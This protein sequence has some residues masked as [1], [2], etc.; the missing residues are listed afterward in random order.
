MNPP[1][2]RVSSKA[3]KI[4]SIGVRCLG[5]RMKGRSEVTG[6][7]RI[8]C[9][10]RANRTQTAVELQ[11]IVDHAL[12]GE[13][14]AGAGVSQLG[15][16]AAHGAVLTEHTNVFGKAGSVIRAEVEGCIS[17]DFAEARDVIGHDG[18][19]GKRGLEQGHPQWFVA[20]GSGIDRC[21]AVKCAQLRFRLR[22]TDR[23]GGL[24]G[25]Y[26]HI[27]ADRNA[28]HWHR[29]LRS[30]NAN[31]YRIWLLSEKEDL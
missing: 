29:M 22:A 26:L 13:T 6:P 19:P 25:R 3:K 30:H 20:R 5:R 17:P 23:N 31:G 28:W 8:L 15:V 9:C 14:L 4:S 1:T 24:V 10:A 2:L 7:P 16:G 11:A 21:A 18:T 27:G 12:G